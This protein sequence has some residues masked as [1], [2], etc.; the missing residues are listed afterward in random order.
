MTQTVL[1]TGANR[2]I[3]KALAEKC[4]QNNMFV[5]LVCRNSEKAK[6]VLHNILSQ[7]GKA[8]LK[9]CDVSNLSDIEI[10][11]KDIKQEFQ[12]LD[13]LINCA[14]INT[15]TEETSIQNMPVDLLYDT[16]Q[17][18]FFG[19]VWMCKE[20]IPLLKKSESGRIINFSSGLGQLSVPRMGPFPAYSMS[21]TAVNA[22]TKVLADEVKDSNIIVTSVDPGWVATDMGGPNA[23][24]SIEEGI[25]TPFWLATAPASD[26]QSG[27]FYKER[28]ILDW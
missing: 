23:M 12:S 8:V 17:T 14:A 2:G 18:N 3:G 9:K 22:L 20:F 26:L 25:D 19:S 5:I 1:I 24:L 16:M 4:A 11:G 27:Y 21:K 15:D 7:G 13:I 6:P 10:L 28:K